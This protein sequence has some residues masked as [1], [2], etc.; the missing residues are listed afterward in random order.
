L[1]FQDWLISMEA[2]LFLKRKGGGIDKVMG[3]GVRTERRG[4]RG[5]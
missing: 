4:G 3:G 2:S 5:N 1:I